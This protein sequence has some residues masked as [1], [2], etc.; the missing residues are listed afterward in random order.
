MLFSPLNAAFSLP[1]WITFN[2]NN[3]IGLELTFLALG[4]DTVSTTCAGLTLCTPQNNLLITP[5]I[6]QVSP[7]TIS[8]RLLTK[9]LC[10][11]LLVDGPRF[12]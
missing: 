2:L 6:Q 11:F 9:Q 10:H 12:R 5:A 8:P 3:Q 1:N 4:T 7:V